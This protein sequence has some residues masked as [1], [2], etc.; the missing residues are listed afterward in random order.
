MPCEKL[1]CDVGFGGGGGA[2]VD[3][4]GGHTFLFLSVSCGRIVYLFMRPSYSLSFKKG[5]NSFHLPILLYAVILM[6]FICSNFELRY[7]KTKRKRVLKQLVF[8]RIILNHGE[9]AK[10]ALH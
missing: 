6:C 3:E 9:R 2:R 8:C 1:L 7:F 10:S 4:E 5:Y